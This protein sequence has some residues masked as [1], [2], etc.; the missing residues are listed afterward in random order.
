MYV[1]E[2]FIAREIFIIMYQLFKTRQISVLE[3]S[4]NTYYHVGKI[5]IRRA[6][7]R[8]EI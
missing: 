6:I 2:L 8:Q 4:I 1:L 7:S 5:N 3:I